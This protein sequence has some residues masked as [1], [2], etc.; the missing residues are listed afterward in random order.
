MRV[1]RYTREQ[2]RRRRRI[3]ALLLAALLLVTVGSCTL[4]VV[5]AVRGP[6][7][8]QAAERTATPQRTSRADHE[9]VSVPT[10]PAGA[11]A[12]SQLPGGDGL[13]DGEVLGIDVSSHQQGIDW[14]QVRGAGISFAYIKAT[15]GSGHVD[16]RFTA[17]WRGARKAG[18]AR[19]A[20][21]YFTLCSTGE[22][23]AID[24]LNAV[25]PDETDLPP[26][27]DLELDG[28]CAARPDA[29]AVDHEVDAFV[30][31][32]EKGWGRR[33]VV[34][35]S[36]DWRN[37]Y[38]LP[39]ETGRPQWLMQSAA[40]PDD[41][42]DIWQVRFDARVPGIDHDVDLDVMHVEKLRTASAISR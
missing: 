17:N 5:R 24:F 39:E 29:A 41:A 35:S 28:S 42:W 10:T 26:A 25:P 1:P 21:H 16:E 40:R 32:V 22:E 27:L 30:A 9:R 20:Y 15:E 13:Q 7:A 11:T 12:L 2:V 36:W 19:G 31:A 8:P 34:Y 3:A 14:K 38:P 37:A 6:S 33:V 4:G 23:Q 18:V